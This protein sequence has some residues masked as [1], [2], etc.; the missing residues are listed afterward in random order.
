MYLAPKDGTLVRLTISLKVPITVR[1]AW[2][3]NSWRTSNYALG[4]QNS[5]LVAYPVGWQY[6]NRRGGKR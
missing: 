5:I 1:A 2:R 6:L 3:H 4:S